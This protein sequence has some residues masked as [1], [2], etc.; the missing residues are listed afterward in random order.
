MDNKIK[1]IQILRGVAS[2]SVVYYHIGMSPNFGA[3]GIDLFFVISGFVMS[4]LLTYKTMKSPWKFYIKRII[5]IVP[6]YYLFTTI[7]LTLTLIKPDLFNSTTFDLLNFFKSLLFIPYIKEDGTLH[8]FL[9]VGWT[10][11][12]E[13]FL[14]LHFHFIAIEIKIFFSF[15]N[16]LVNNIFFNMY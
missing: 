11:N 16:I 15:F 7:T 4:L 6:L 12:Y 9:P 8:P 5:R 2:T 13:F 3:F 14:F 1:S 10:L